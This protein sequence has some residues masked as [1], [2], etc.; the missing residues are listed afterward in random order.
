MK[1]LNFIIAILFGAVVFF[2]GCT[3]EEELIA[4]PAERL[5]GT[6]QISEATALGMTLDMSGSTV[7]FNS[8]GDTQCEGSDYVSY[9]DVDCPFIYTLTETNLTIEYPDQNAVGDFSGDWTIDSF[10]NSA[11][12]LSMSTFLGDVSYKL[13]K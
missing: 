10:T 5:L 13:T 8:C 3:E 12:N 1:K 11:M 7:T 4:D 9:D 2:S 6:W